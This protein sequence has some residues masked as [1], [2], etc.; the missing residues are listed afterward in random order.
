MITGGNIM[1]R[2]IGV[3][4]KNPFNGK[5]ELYK[6]PREF[7]AKLK[8]SN[9]EELG[10]S[11]VKLKKVIETLV[12]TYTDVNDNDIQKIIPFKSEVKARGK[13]VELTR[14]GHKD[15]CMKEVMELEDVK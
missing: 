10:Y 15:I 7:E 6:Y 2:Y 3:F 9:L 5:M 12:V 13:F 1:K 14:I 11:D 8:A 4:A